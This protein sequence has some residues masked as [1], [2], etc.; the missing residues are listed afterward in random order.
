ML[1]AVRMAMA[2]AAGWFIMRS[3]DLARLWW[4]IPARDLFGF[5]VWLA[6]LFGSS[7]VWRGERLRLDRQGRIQSR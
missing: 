3:R 7:V 6:G 2:L 4:L 1:L 5:T